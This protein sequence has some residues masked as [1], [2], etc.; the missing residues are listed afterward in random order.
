M[1]KKKKTLLRYKR[2]GIISKKLEKKFSNFLQANIDKFN[3]KIEE[4]VEKV[5]E[6]LEKT[7]EIIE[8]AKQTESTPE[9][10]VE[11]KPKPATKRRTTTKKKATTTKKTAPQLANGELLKQKRSLG[12]LLPRPTSYII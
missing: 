12:Y 7:Q 8:S 4:V 2:L 10:T 5:E 3:T 6:T 9:P 1:G 11:E